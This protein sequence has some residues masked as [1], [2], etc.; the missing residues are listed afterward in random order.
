MT[1]VESI[2]ESI[3]NCTDIKNAM[4]VYGRESDT[5][6]EAAKEQ[7]I[8]T[9]VYLEPI[10]KTIG[11]EDATQTANIV[12]GFLTQDE[13]DSASDAE[14]SE[15]ST[16]SMEEKVADMETAA[17]LWLT[18]FFDNYTYR[19]NGVYTL[20]PVFRIKNVMTG[21]LLTFSLIEPKQC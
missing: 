14:V 9:F 12:I 15:A 10:S 6:L 2:R 20:A 3:N 1:L 13:P 18:Y 8:G 4:F 7:N 21:V 17:G 5:A 16:L 11:V 19:I